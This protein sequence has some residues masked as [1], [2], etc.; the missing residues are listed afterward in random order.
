MHPLLSS[1][2][3]F[4]Q[5]L[6]KDQSW[7]RSLLARKNAVASDS[8]Y[9]AASDHMLSNRVNNYVNFQA[10][11]RIYAY[12]AP[13]ADQPLRILDL[14]CGIGDKSILLSHLFPRWRISGLETENHDDHE[15]MQQ[16]PDKFFASVYPHIRTEYSITC[17]LY[18]GLHIPTEGDG[19]D[20]IMLYAVIEHI[21]PEHRQT[22]IDHA[23][24][25]LKPGGHIIITRC[26]RRWGLM[27]FISRRLHLGAHEWTLRRTDLLGLFDPQSWQVKCLNI[28]NNIPNNSGLSRRFAAPLIILDRILQ[29]L[30]YPFA[31]DY[32]LIVSRRERPSS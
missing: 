28:H 21:A 12:F 30:H 10:F 19:Y 4:E 7:F 9:C 5:G 26:P 32:F 14:G 1:F 6:H 8:I 3:A 13:I 29:T 31:T 24:A 11:R 2:S 18:D 20:I 23:L 17:G 16:H 27:E 22:F 25:A 15:H